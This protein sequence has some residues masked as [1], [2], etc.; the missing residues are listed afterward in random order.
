MSFIIKLLEMIY[1]AE[2]DYMERLPV[3]LHGSKSYAIADG[4]IIIIDAIDILWSVYNE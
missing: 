4:S 3:N 2:Y 1:Y